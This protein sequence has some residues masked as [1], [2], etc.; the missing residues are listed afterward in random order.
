MTRVVGLAAGLGT[1]A[2]AVVLG[3]L[4]FCSPCCSLYGWDRII[5]SPGRFGSVL[6]GA[7]FR[8]QETGLVWE[9]QHDGLQRS[10]VIA[11]EL[12]M[13]RAVGGRKGW[14]LPTYNELTSLLDPAQTG[15]ALPP[16]H[17]FADIRSDGYWSAST[18][19]FSGTHA[20]AADFN[21][22]D[23]SMVA[24]SNGL[25]VRCVRGPEAGPT[26]Y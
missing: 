2:V 10:W 15:P 3:T 16:G 23:V 9:A 24:K 17:P 18:S 21:L 8:D 13:N 26:V 14:R 20:V 1:I 12:C 5:A 7:A 19:A 22:G 4:Y 25:W 11:R 6:G